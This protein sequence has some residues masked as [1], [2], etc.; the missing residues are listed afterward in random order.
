MPRGRLRARPWPR[1]RAESAWGPSRE[2][3]R[4]AVRRPQSPEERRPSPRVSLTTCCDTSRVTALV[5]DY[6]LIIVFLAIA[7]ETA[8]LPPPGEPTLVITA[9]APP[10][11]P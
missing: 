1:A 2:R 4:R 11:A 10:P 9:L 7:L 8:A 6:G 3:A 5:R